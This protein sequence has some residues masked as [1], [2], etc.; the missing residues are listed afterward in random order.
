MSKEIGDEFVQS[1]LQN[2]GAINFVPSCTLFAL[3]TNGDGNCLMHAACLAMFAIQDANRTLR[4]ALARV[5]S[6]ATW[7]LQVQDKWRTYI[8][9]NQAALPEE[10]QVSSDSFYKEWEHAVLL[11]RL[12]PEDARPDGHAYGIGGCSLLNIHVY[13]LAQMLHRPIIIYADEESEVDSGESMAGIYLPSLCDSQ[14][15]SRQPLL[16][17]YTP[18]HFTALIP[19]RARTS[20]AA[21]SSR[22]GVPLRVRFEDGRIPWQGLAGTFMNL[23]RNGQ[24][25]FVAALWAG[26]GAGSMDEVLPES[27]TVIE[28]YLRGAQGRCDATPLS[29]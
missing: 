25:H 3:R 20:H 26:A 29:P 24:G 1:Q 16:I 21:L 12:S 5:M 7:I 8:S 22:S 27:A 14:R 23:Q 6:G 15:C 28:N 13:I 17:A 19:H 10:F 4:N 18:G 11:P 2:K 9:Q